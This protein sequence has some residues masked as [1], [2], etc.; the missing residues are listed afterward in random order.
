MA[1]GCARD[2]GLYSA[3]RSIWSGGLRLV[4][5]VSSGVIVAS[6][7]AGLA[8]EC[9]ASRGHFTSAYATASRDQVTGPA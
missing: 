6:S 4:S 5:Q 1:V 2:R 7:S 9:G 8:R 3:A